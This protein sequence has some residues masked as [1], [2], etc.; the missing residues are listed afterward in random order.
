MVPQLWRMRSFTIP[1]ANSILP[2]WNCS[3]LVELRLYTALPQMVR[4]Y[5]QMKNGLYHNIIHHLSTGRLFQM[6]KIFA[7]QDLQ[8]VQQKWTW[9]VE[10]T[11]VLGVL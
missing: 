9:E 10:E 11:L 6:V 5:L 2:T 8:T 3:K 7:R 1:L 4:V